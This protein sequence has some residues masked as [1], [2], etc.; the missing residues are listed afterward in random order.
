MCE[1]AKL[2]E[3]DIVIS[4]IVGAAGLLP[5]L[6]AVKAGKTLG[7]ANKESLVLAGELIKKEAKKSGAK[8]NSC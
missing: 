2:K 3:A 5:T 1:L 4:A 6:E 7:L 8:N